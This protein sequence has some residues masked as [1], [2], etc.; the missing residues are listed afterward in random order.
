MDAQNSRVALIIVI[1][2]RWPRARRRKALTLRD[3]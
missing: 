3:A 2:V 1:A